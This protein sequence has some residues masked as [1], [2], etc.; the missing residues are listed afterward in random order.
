MSVLSLR[1]NAA[2]KMKQALFTLIL[3]TLAGAAGALEPPGLREAIAKH[4]E[5]RAETDRRFYGAHIPSVDAASYEF[6]YALVD[7]NGD[8]IP[9]AIVQFK[10]PKYCG[11]GGCT[12]E[13][14]RG[15]KQGFEFISGSTSSREPIQ[16]IAETHFGWQ[17]FAVSVSGGGAKSC[18]A[19]MRFNGQKYPL[20]PSLAP[21]A[22]SAQLQSATPVT[23][24][25]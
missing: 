20:N 11:S 19:L 25:P 12:L 10:G 13:V 5:L 16:L 6:R 17:S 18:N 9:D 22:T 21:C 15:T 7:L 4:D 8:G 23:M 24:T 14:F 2:T 3:C 1:N